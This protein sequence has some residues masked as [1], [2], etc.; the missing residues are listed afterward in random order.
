M[1]AQKGVFSSLVRARYAVTGIVT[2]ATVAVSRRV[3]E[4]SNQMGRRTG[5][6]LENGNAEPSG[7]KKVLTH[8]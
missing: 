3:H 4:R 1:I 8:A 7:V 5:S 2:D 6:N